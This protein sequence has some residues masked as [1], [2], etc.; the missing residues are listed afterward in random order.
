MVDLHGLVNIT[1]VGAVDT[2]TPKSSPRIR[3]TF[4]SVP[5]APVT[6]FTLN[7]YGGK[8]GLLVNN[9]N[10]CKHKLKAK[11]ALTGQNGHAYNTEPVVKV[12]SCKG[13]KAAKKSALRR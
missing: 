3:T 11:A 8:R 13:G 1:L 6:S 2:A 7:L 9:R 5:D 12:A 4:S 10:L